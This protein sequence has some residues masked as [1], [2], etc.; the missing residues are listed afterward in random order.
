[1][2]KFHRRLIR[3]LALI[4]GLAPTRGFTLI[5]LLIVIVIIGVL[6]TMMVIAV[7]PTTSTAAA[8]AILG[9]LRALQTASVAYYTDHMSSSD[10]GTGNAIANL[11]P[12]IAASDKVTEANGYHFEAA[13]DKSWWVGY[14]GDKLTD[15]VKA[16]LADK[17]ADM[18][19]KAEKAGAQF[20]SGATAVWLKAK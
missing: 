9:D 12:Y 18:G 4:R 11:A 2:R 15:E 8:T 20:T 6:A 10:L 16:K 14:S 19:L 7:G 3:S 5:E 17:T 13:T 1:M